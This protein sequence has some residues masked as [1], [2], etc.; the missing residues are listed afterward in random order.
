MRNVNDFFGVHRA[1]LAEN[2]V[3]YRERLKRGLYCIIKTSKYKHP[4]I[5]LALVTVFRLKLYEDDRNLKKF[6]KIISCIQKLD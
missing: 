3:S 4:S 2:V 6:L 5:T 1:C